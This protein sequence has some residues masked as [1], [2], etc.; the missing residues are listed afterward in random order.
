MDD[1]VMQFR[2]G[3]MFLATFLIMGILLLWFGQLPTLTGRNY[4]IR[5]QFDSAAGV[6]KDTPVRKSGILIGRVSDI[7][8]S[9]QD[10]NV[11]ITLAI[12]ADK[13]IYQNE[14][15]CITRDLMGNTA[16]SF[17]AN[18][19]KSAH[20]QPIDRE[21]IL[22]G[23][24]S[25][26][27]TGLMTALSEPIDNIKNTGDA[28]TAASKQLGEAA[29]R[30]EDIRS[31]D[32]QKDVQDILRDAAKSLRVMQRMLGDEDNQT[33]LTESLRRLPDTLDNMN[34]TFQATDD[35]LR[36]FTEPS[37]VDGKTPVERMVG[38]IEMTERTLRKFSESA[39]PLRGM[40]TV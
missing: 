31:P 35:M 6:T 17:I 2:V 24:V 32:A 21:K 29:K 36:K 16:I 15:C 5:V 27:P 20:R 22:I 3:V 13:H 23:K 18:S 7:R 28:L 25:N 40:V 38:T 39:E 1:R 8:L 33:K 14:D 26:D 19:E 37:R 12:Q 10:A 34:R 11:L 9:D 4:G 30:V